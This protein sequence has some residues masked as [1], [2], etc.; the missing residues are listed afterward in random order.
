MR[1][2][3]FGLILG[4]LFASPG[5]ARDFGFSDVVARAEALARKGYTPPSAVPQFLQD[6][7]FTQYQGIRFKPEMSLWRNR[8]LFHVM[9]V[10]PGYY[11]THPV[12][13]NVVDDKGVRPVD[14]QRRYFS[15][16]PED[17]DIVKRIPPDLGYA[18]FKLTYP[19][20]GRHIQNQFLVFAGASYFRGVGKDNNFGISARGIAVDTGL[21]SGEEF[22]SFIEFWLVRPAPQARSMTFYALLDGASLTGAYAF[23]VHPGPVTRVAVTANLFP[24]KPVT[25]L[26]LAPLT[27]MFYYGENTPRPSY[28]WRPQVHDSDGLLIHDGATG[29]WLWRPLINPR[30]LEMDYFETHRIDGFG[31]LQRQIHFED[32]E[33]LGARYEARPSAWVQAKGDWGKG[34]VVLVQLPAAKETSDNIV[35]FWTPDNGAPVDRPLTLSYDLSFG[36]PAV[37]REPMGRALHTFV[38]DGSVIGGGEVKGAYRVVVDFEG[39]P[40]T[41]LPGE[42]PVKAVVTPQDGGK[43]IEQFVEYVPPL[44]RWRLSILAQPKDG[45]SL[46]LRAFLK[47][48]DRT[49]TETWTYR[50]PPRNAIAKRG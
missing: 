15:F 3:T 39:G 42:G 31:L 2:M 22:P 33:D 16:S 47:D 4:V 24:R 49:L 45:K 5:F 12:K 38:G 37:A 27:S 9:L 18:G 7:T 21:P 30:Q 13:I 40:L 32:Y 35:A 36:T 44:H 19:L 48:H 25:L 1:S 26:G 41:H 14:F 11:F 20:R 29:E 46:S 17:G 23:H 28:E 43:V 50:L 6:L 10:S 34:H 8:S